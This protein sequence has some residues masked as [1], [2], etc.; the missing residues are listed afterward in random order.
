MTD[1]RKEQFTPGPWYIRPRTAEQTVLGT[2]TY[3][4]T[5]ILDDANGKYSPKHV[6]AQI[7][8]GNGREEANA[9]LIAAAPEMYDW[10][11]AA[12]AEMQSICRMFG[13]PDYVRES[14]EQLIE[15]GE[16]IQKKARGEK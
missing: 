15:R 3:T 10:Q 13:V 6:I 14:L 16:A 12:L 4:R 2:T 11:T 1:E 9:A 7:A 8:R 5:T